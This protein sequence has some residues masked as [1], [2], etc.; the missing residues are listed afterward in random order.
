MADRDELAGSE[1]IDIIAIDYYRFYLP[2]TARKTVHNIGAM[3]E[4]RSFKGSYVR[5]RGLKFVKLS[6]GQ[7]EELDI[8]LNCYVSPSA[9][10]INIKGGDAISN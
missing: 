2:G 8:L 7:E 1:G 9:K 6:K 3:M 5:N 4:G 10:K